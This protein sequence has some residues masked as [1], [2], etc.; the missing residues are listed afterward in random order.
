[1]KIG[2]KQLKKHYIPPQTSFGRASSIAKSPKEDLNQ[3]ESF[4]LHHQSPE[5]QFIRDLTFLERKL[6]KCEISVKN[7]L[8]PKNCGFIQ[9]MQFY[10]DYLGN[11]CAS[12]K[13][14]DSRLSKSIIRGLIGVEK[15]FKKMVQK[16]NDDQVLISSLQKPQRCDGFMQTVQECEGSGKKNEEVLPEME[17]FKQLAAVFKR[18]RVNRVTERLLELYESLCQM[19]TDVP[20][21]TD[22]PDPNLQ[23]TSPDTIMSMHL[24]VIKNHVYHILTESKSEVAKITS[25]KS[26]QAEF[27]ISQIPEVRVLEKSVYNK[28]QE[29]IKIKEKIESFAN[30]KFILE[31]RM[32]KMQN[33]YN[34]VEKKQNESEIES[35]QLKTKFQHSEVVII[36]QDKRIKWFDGKLM[37]KTEKLVRAKLRIDELKKI[38]VKKQQVM[39]KLQEELFDTRI[40]WKIC[41]EKLIDIEHAWER[42][43]G[44]RYEYKTIDVDILIS[45]YGIE[46]GDAEDSNEKMVLDDSDSSVSDNIPPDAE[47]FDEMIK[48]NLRGMKE[49]PNL[50]PHLIKKKNEFSKIFAGSRE[51]FENSGEIFENSG[52]KEE[53]G[54][55]FLK[56]V[57]KKF[58]YVENEEDSESSGEPHQ[59]KVQKTRQRL[60]HSTKK[61][62]KKELDSFD[63]SLSKESIKEEFISTIQSSH[64]SSIKPSKGHRNSNIKYRNMSQNVEI[65]DQD[66]DNMKDSAHP[67]SIQSYSTKVESSNIVKIT[68]KTAKT[69]VFSSTLQVT[70]TFPSNKA[71]NSKVQELFKLQKKLT[72]DLEKKEKEFVN[73]FVNEQTNLFCQYK[74]LKNELEKVRK[75]LNIEILSTGIQCCLLDDNR[76]IFAGCVKRGK[77]S[78]QGVGVEAGKDPFEE[79]K[80]DEDA[81]VLLGTV[82]DNNKALQGLSLS[83]K[84]QIVKS[85]KGHKLD[86]CKEMCPHLLRVLKIKW[87]SKGAL[88]PIR[89]IMMKSVDF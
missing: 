13:F 24:K 32:K 39:S 89:N 75:E 19:Q 59:A 79:I 22:M 34:E 64:R 28:E 87:K 61:S 12:F 9:E 25:D 83:D 8:M 30:E 47:E 17:S 14:K 43:T 26:C 88:Y 69:R 68:T 23:D 86:K 45:K 29:I 67:P 49:T 70:E 80:D 4:N 57:T 52:K 7:N 81:K 44:R 74:N 78:G 66:L 46:K 82:F 72:I 62:S 1:M 16:L 6:D 3:T 11:V 18:I 54:K 41:E 65:S 48:E 85:L 84:M 2:M 21:L 27:I 73:T 36:A 5:F 50:P 55:N 35:F 51:V 20:E 31:D 60:K 53:S 63:N 58:E 40:S 71:N 76:E 38:I 15:T 77:N 42:K 10:L 37:K 33:F 56:K